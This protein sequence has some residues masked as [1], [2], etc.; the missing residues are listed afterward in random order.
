MNYSYVSKKGLSEEVVR[1]ISKQ[2]GEPEWMLE[3]RLEAYRIF[4][5]KPLPK[6][7]IDLSGINFDDIYYYIKPTDKKVNAWD[8]LPNEIKE[9]FDKLGVPEAERKFFAGTEAQFDSEVVY[10][11]IK[12]ALEAQGVIF[13]DTDTAL[14]K[15]PDLVK[16]Y[17]GTVVAA[18]DNK[19]AALNTAVWS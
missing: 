4:A 6:W 18:S 11:N 13:C 2:K 7:G 12:K 5:S 8:L 16:K 3:K 15:Y 14:K 9:T 1:D 17:F 10:S 19:F